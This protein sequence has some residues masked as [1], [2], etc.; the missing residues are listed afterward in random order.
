MINE[1]INV[2]ITAQQD[3]TRT[4]IY[5]NTNGGQTTDPAQKLNTGQNLSIHDDD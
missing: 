2:S 1:V 3:K 5:R 4:F